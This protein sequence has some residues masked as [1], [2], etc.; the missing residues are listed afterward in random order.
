[1]DWLTSTDQMGNKLSLAAVPQRIVS[2]VPSQTELLYDLGLDDQVVG[3]TKFCVRPEHWRKTKAIIGGTKKF[4]LEGIANLNPD[5]ILGNKEENYPEGILK[6]REKFPVWMSDI[7]TLDQAISMVRSVGAMTDRRQQ[8][9]E[10]C[11]AIHMNFEQL[12]RRPLRRALYMMW[13]NPWMGAG[14]NTFIHAMLAEAGFENV[15]G[16]MERYPELT[17]GQMA[18]LDPE[19]VLLSSEP[20][21]FADKHIPEVARLLP[22]AS[23][24]LVD[25]EFFSWYGSRL[26]LAP[27]YFNSLMSRL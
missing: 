25:G 9:D 21:P 22:R 14:R 27:E 24:V 12:E 1:M 19:V 10:L 15:L 11:S 18:E 8:G 17:A 23:I 20:F 3:I 4:D 7:A 26:R 6:L 16:E 5:L 2:L 13:R